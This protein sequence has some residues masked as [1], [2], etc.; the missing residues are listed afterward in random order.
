MRLKTL[1]TAVLTAAAVAVALPAAAETKIGVIRTGYVVQ[2]SPQYKASEER[3]KAEFDKRKTDIDTQG[4]QL[5]E[6]IK[7]FQRDGDTLTPADRQKTAKDLDSRQLD[8]QY[9]QKKFQDD[10]STR[11]RELT[12]NLMDTINATI[13]QVA[14]EK[15]YDIVIPDPVYASTAVDITDDVVKRLATSK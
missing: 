11:D 4:K 5:A 2:N 14:K 10:L 12:K 9:A 13:Q 15:G 8:L 6:D 7:K 3:I 1:T